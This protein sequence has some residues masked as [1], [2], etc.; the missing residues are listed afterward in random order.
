MKRW[1]AVYTY[2]RAEKQVLERLTLEGIETYLPLQ[3]KLKYW[4]DRKKWV[5]EPLFRSYIF[6]NINPDK[7]YFKVLNTSGVVCFIKFENK[8]ASI[9]EKQILAV[10][11]L[12]TSGLTYEITN[13]ELDPGDY[14]QIVYGEMKGYTGRLV[15]YRGRYNVLLEID[16]IRQNVVLNIP[17][18]HVKK[19]QPD[20]AI[21]SFG[22][23]IA[24]TGNI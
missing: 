12:M 24:R 17:A 2:S 9:P 3:K 11:S 7:D 10:K 16:N 15:D 18:E 23:P 6:V 13:E 4:S 21:A 20:Y 5:E 8:L 22:V 19:M 14:L 1:Y